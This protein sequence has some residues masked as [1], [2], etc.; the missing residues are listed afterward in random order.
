MFVHGWDQ[1]TLLT[2][3]LKE[4]ADLILVKM[5]DVVQQLAQCQR[6]EENFSRGASSSA[7]LGRSTHPSRAAS[8]EVFNLLRASLDRIPQRLSRHIGMMS[9]VLNH[10]VS[11]ERHHHSEQHQS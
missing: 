11:Q 9:N 6:S 8:P 7:W 4:R 2:K 10:V 1:Q 5:N 3:H